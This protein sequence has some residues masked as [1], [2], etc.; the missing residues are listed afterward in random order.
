MK[1]YH[2]YHLY[3]NK[4]ET[5]QYIGQGTRSNYAERPLEHFSGLYHFN[6]NGQYETSRGN[7]AS[8][9]P[10]FIK[11]LHTIRL[12]DVK[13]I[14][15]DWNDKFGISDQDWVAFAREWAPSAIYDEVLK[16]SLEVAQNMRKLETFEDVYKLWGN[17]AF[18]CDA[19]EIIHIY[20]ATASGHNL[21]QA[22]M[23]GQIENW[24]NLKNNS[25]LNR[26]MSPS[27]MTSIINSS[28]MKDI[29][30]VQEAFNTSFQR[31][32]SKDT[33]FLK[34][35]QS[36]VQTKDNLW[37][38]IK[39]TIEEWLKTV[40]Q[41]QTILQ[42][43][44]RDVQNEC[45][46]HLVNFGLQFPKGHADVDAISITFNTKEVQTL[47]KAITNAIISN[48]DD[49]EQKLEKDLSL[50]TLAKWLQEKVVGHISIGTFIKVNL[51][52]IS[53]TLGLG[54]Q[55]GIDYSETLAPYLKLKSYWY[56][57]HFANQY[58]STPNYEVSTS[59]YDVDDMGFAPFRRVFGKPSCTNYIW[60][61]YRDEGI[62]NEYTMSYAQW[63]K[64]N[65]GM[66]S[67][68]TKNHG[69]GWFD[70]QITPTVLRKN[71][72]EEFENPILAGY[73]DGGLPDTDAHPF[74]KF[75]STTWEYINTSFNRNIEDLEDY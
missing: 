72:E 61:C 57:M 46:A 12:K 32:L 7:R 74:Y 63:L 25:V 5:E 47:E 18:I 64:F 67:C 43:I 19:A 66:L 45:D 34:K 58:F 11:W 35:L 3:S 71:I 6:K 52:N 24:R 14:I 75:S 44:I 56:F 27:A 31:H 59:N 62:K 16:K 15:W 2:I 70:G 20:K 17:G 37:Y 26:D 48:K 68:Y 54:L 8:E 73:F 10:A 9:G 60:Q 49:L 22:Q 13:C 53:N 51:K 1:R 69:N 40:N 23:G 30:S 65:R 55:S 4:N 50:E 39:D 21:L 38:A 33:F 36:A 41:K 42:T 28:Q 29:N